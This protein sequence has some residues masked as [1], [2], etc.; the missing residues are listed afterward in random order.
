[1][2]LTKQLASRQ[3]GPAHL[4]LHRWC[5]KGRSAETRDQLFGPRS[6]HFVFW[7]L[8]S[9]LFSGNNGRFMFQWQMRWEKG[10]R[11]IARFGNLNRRSRHGPEKKTIAV[12]H[13]AADLRWIKCHP[14]NIGCT[15][16]KQLSHTPF[17]GPQ[18][19]TRIAIKR[20]CNCK[21]RPLYRK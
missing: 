20:D 13:S 7:V 18:F 21:S 9:L 14:Y 1:M 12:M 17:C 6:K 4:V 8:S 5:I 2:H 10:S 16:T 3:P 15:E 11:S 19:S